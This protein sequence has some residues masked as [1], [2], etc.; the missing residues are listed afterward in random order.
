MFQ[1]VN[2]SLYDCRK[3]RS[4]VNLILNIILA[5]VALLLVFQISFGVFYQGFYIV[6]SS[7][8]PT[9]T[10][11]TD[12]RS[13]GGD[14]IYVNRYAKP[15]YG[16]IV[17][18]YDGKQ[19][20]VKRVIAFGGDAVKIERGVVSVRYA[21]D[22]SFTVLSESYVAENN[23]TPSA[24]A[25]NFPEHVVEEDCYFLLGD[26]RDVS[27]DSR[28]NGDYAASGLIGVMPAWAMRYKSCTTALHNFFQ[29]TL[30]QA[31]GGK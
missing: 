3:S 13:A 23:N 29:F 26:N 25:N 20:I 27:L 12:I 7:M 22:D 30:P 21:G 11:A 5:L 10:G 24:P 8:S 4:A 19:S 2:Q 31:F 9:L 16:D 6:H 17:V 14:Y 1:Q 18:V 15:G 28:Q